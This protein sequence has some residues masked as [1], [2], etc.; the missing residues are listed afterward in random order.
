[1]PQPICYFESKIVQNTQKQ[2]FAL[3]IIFDDAEHVPANRNK[4]KKIADKF[5]FSSEKGVTQ[6]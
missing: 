3:D 5:D 6:N 1:M 2:H 4:A